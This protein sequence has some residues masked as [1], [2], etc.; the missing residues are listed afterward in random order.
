[1]P[2]PRR[3]RAACA[4]AA[5]VLLPG[6]CARPEPRPNVLLIVADD[7]GYNDLAINNGDPD[8]HTPSLDALAREGVRFTRH[9]ADAVCSPARAALLTGLN[10]ARAGYVPNGRGM[11]PQLL[12]LAEAL[13]AQGYAT[14]HVG[15]WHIGD[16][17][18]AAWPDRQGFG[19][20]FGFLNQFYLAGTHQGDELL[21][22]T[23]RHVDPWLMT[24]GD[25]GKRYDGYLDDILT[26][27]AEAYIRELGAAGTPWF[28][29][30]W[31]Y[32]PHAPITPAPRVAAG[33][34]DTP[35]GHYRAMVEQLDG[36]VGRVIAALRETGQ[37][38]DTVIVFVS[39]N[40]GTAQQRARSNA[41]YQGGKASFFEGGVRTPLVIRW[42]HGAGA[43]TVRDD[44]V[45]I[46]DLYPTLLAGLGVPV[47]PGLDGRDLGVARAAASPPRQL[48]WETY[49]GGHFGYSLLRDARWRLYKTWPWTPWEAAPLLQDTAADPGAP[50][51]R[52]A[53]E[54]G[55]LAALEDARRAWQRDVQH[56]RL[57]F[58]REDDGRGVLTGLDFL[59]T[60]GFGGFTFGIALQPGYTGT[61][62]GQQGIWQL[63]IDAGER[64][65]ASFQDHALQGSLPATGCRSAIVSG[66]F[67][68]KLS[69]WPGA[70]D[71]IALTLYLDGEAVDRLDVEGRLDDTN[72]AAPTI[73]GLPGAPQANA[74]LSEPLL[75]ITELGASD[76]WDPAGL[77]RALC[78]EPA[79]AG[80]Q[81]K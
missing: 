22:D 40:G 4:L 35:D 48:Y 31:Y 1:M 68:R 52:A 77:H 28:L 10:A 46:Y 56:P 13:Q 9:Y 44:L 8:V 42:P 23:P 30:L 70:M 14:V 64:V 59:R 78:A 66:W 71:H 37:L 24:D 19:H 34:P 72:F 47:P 54:P 80:R 76:A 73:T 65:T 12:T 32:L 63:A 57:D 50:P 58:R 7:L 18:R 45:A 11:S 26:A 75:L 33:Y 20:W 21:E 43:G 81:T 39:D 49:S 51:D 2:L 41:P 17:L 16:K 74:R 36:N 53:A 15:K 55:L 29:N 27:H 67:T 3:L 62:A 60:P 25:A 38:E 61:I 79:Q 5:L 69:N 6:A